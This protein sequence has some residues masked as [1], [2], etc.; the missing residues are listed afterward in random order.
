MRA[1]HFYALHELYLF[2]IEN[3]PNFEDGCEYGKVAMM[4]I[5]DSNLLLAPLLSRTE[6]LINERLFRNLSDRT[7]LPHAISAKIWGCDVLVAYDQHFISISDVI[8]YKTPEEIIEQIE[9]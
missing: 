9:N 5:I 8:P 7:D 2:A 6:R 3:A 1:P 4:R